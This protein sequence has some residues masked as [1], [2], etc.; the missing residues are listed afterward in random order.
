MKQN[1]QIVVEGCGIRSRNSVVDIATSYWLDGPGFES[2]QRQ[3]IFCSR[4]ALVP[5]QPPFQWILG[6]LPGDKALTA[7]V[8][9]V[10]R[11]RMC[12]TIH[13]LRLYVFMAWTET[14]LPF[15]VWLKVRI[16]RH[17]PRFEP[18]TSRIR[19]KVQ[20]SRLLR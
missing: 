10:P 12:G 5:T 18:G 19:K 3:Q 7:H 2:R 20:L 16:S 6:F 1:K 11:S 4:P 9:L 8:L 13:L 15:T 17:R 14:T